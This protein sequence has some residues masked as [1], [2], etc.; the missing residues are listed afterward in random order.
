M[1][2]EEIEEQLDLGTMPIRIRGNMAEAQVG[3]DYGNVLQ[4]R[5]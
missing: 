5:Y 3:L 1:T 4:P 2:P